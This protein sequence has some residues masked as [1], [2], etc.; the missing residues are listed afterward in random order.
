MCQLFFQRRLTDLPAL[1]RIQKPL[2]RVR[3]VNAAM[4]AFFRAWSAKSAR[5]NAPRMLDQAALPWFA[6]LNRGLRDTLDDR[7]FDAR[8]AGTFAQLDRLALQIVRRATD[9]HPG[10][11]G[12]SVLELLG[13]DAVPGRESLLFPAAA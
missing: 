8:M 7:A 3:D 10:L 9:E 2:Q 13:A 12:G 4:Q 5:R 1:G 11:D 6:E